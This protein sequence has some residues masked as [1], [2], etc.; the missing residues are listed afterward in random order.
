MNVWA[1]HLFALLWLLAASAAWG[2][3][4][5]WNQLREGGYVI[6]IRH[7]ATEF[8]V[9]DPPGFKLGD[10]KT[11]R[12]LSESGRAEA[13][14]LGEAFR[15][16]GVAVSDVRSSQWCRCLETA[17]IAFGRVEPFPA[18]N[19]VFPDRLQEARQKPVVLKLAAEVKPPDNLVLV[20]HSFNIRALVG[21]SPGTAEIVIARYEGGD[22]K[23]A[24]RIAAP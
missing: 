4:A 10:C 17:R 14:R 24:G 16:H 1:K 23:L 7:G 18:L 9:G 8:G 22:L 5:L 19:S 21:V 13:R 2:D 15:S 12:N 11:Q 20:T 6:L 3:E